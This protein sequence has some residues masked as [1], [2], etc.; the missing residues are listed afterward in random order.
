MPLNECAAIRQITWA[1]ANKMLIPLSAKQGLVARVRKD[2]DLFVR[3]NI[4]NLE[5]LIIQRILMHKEQLI[6]QSLIN[7]L[8]GMLQNSQ[9][10]MQTRLSFSRRRVSGVFWR[11]VG[12]SRPKPAG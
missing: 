1:S 11:Y 10:A 7:D 4:G 8:L 5:Q 9:A 6:T 3:S 2:N 12:Q